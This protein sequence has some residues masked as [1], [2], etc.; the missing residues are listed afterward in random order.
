MHA[1][2]APSWELLRALRLWAATPEERRTRAY[3]ALQDAPISAASESRALCALRAACT[4]VLGTLPTTAQQD[5]DL[6]RQEGEAALGE[7]SRLA[8]EWRLGHKR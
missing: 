7:C 3:L 5:E 1:N 8:V 2:G 4:A 6:Q